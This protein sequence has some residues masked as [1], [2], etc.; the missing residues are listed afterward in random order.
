[1][2]ANAGLDRSHSKAHLSIDNIVVVYLTDTGEEDDSI[3]Q[4]C[5]VKNEPEESKE[6]IPSNV[7]NVSSQEEHKP[8]IQD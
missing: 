8:E 2:E 5:K 6:E 1:M 7:S 4:E 3:A